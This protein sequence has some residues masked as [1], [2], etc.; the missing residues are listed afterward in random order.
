MVIAAG[1][2]DLEFPLIEVAGPRRPWCR[3]KNPYSSRNEIVGTTNRSIDATPSAWLRRNVFHPWLGGRLPRTM[4]LATVVCP[5][6]MPSLRSSPWILGAPQSGLAMLMS[7]IN[8]LTSGA[9][10]GRPPRGR[11]FHR[12]YKRKPARC[13]RITV[14]G[15]T[16][17]KALST[18]GAKPYSPT[19]TVRS[20]LPRIGRLGELP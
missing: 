8:C 11:D 7:R 20:I 2:D 15:L 12:Q 3:I 6:S 17:A 4:Y 9:T 19:N 16:I 18:S 10:F 1:S 13:Q 5:T 14:S